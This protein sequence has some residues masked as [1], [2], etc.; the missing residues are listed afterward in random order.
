MTIPRLN[1]L[2]KSKSNPNLMLILLPINNLVPY[3]KTSNKA[4]HFIQKY[5]FDV[6]N[7]LYYKPNNVNSLI[8]QLAI[9]A[10]ISMTV[11]ICTQI[12]LDLMHANFTMGSLYY[13][14]VKL[15]INGVAEPSLTITKF[16]VIYRQRFFPFI[17]SIGLFSPQPFDL[18]QKMFFWENGVVNGK[19]NQ[20]QR[21]LS[22][23]NF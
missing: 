3:K 21:R 19:Q 20:Y 15:M 18:M 23:I 11:F 5:L 1:S 9:T 12:K 10:I 13:A 2:C 8:Y 4:R 17:P 16:P 6:K 7:I 22:K 14:I